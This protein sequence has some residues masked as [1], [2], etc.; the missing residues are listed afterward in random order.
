[1]LAAALTDSACWVPSSRPK[2]PPSPFTT[3]CSSPRWYSTAL[4]E[5][6]KMITGSTW[7]AKTTPS[8]LAGSTGP[9]RNAMP[10]ADEL[11]TAWTPRDAVSSARWPSDQYRTPTPKPT[12]RASAP[13]TVR[14]RIARRLL[15]TA[16]A[17]DSRTT[18]PPSPHSTSITIS[19]TLRSGEPTAPPQD[20]ADILAWQPWSRQHPEGSS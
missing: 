14:S 9:N 3:H 17:M 18:M 8:S 19:T 16:T 1:M 2:A 5:A 4:S 13:A 12:W 11:I 7:S 6:K 15:E 20:A 10:S